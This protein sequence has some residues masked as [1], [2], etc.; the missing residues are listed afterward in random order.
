MVGSKFIK[1]IWFCFN[2]ILPDFHLQKHHRLIND[3]RHFHAFFFFNAFF[4]SISRCYF[5]FKNDII[6]L[7]NQ[8]L[9]HRLCY[10]FRAALS[11]ALIPLE[12]PIAIIDTSM[13]L[14]LLVQCYYILS[15][16]TALGKI[17]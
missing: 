3:H 4:P 1:I 11:I 7:Q 8:F 12:F 17:N 5:G 6:L 10:I 13:N 15:F 9:P 16:A 2:S 14:P